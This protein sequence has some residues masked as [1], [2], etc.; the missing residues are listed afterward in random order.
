ML[1]HYFD[2]C[3]VILIFFGKQVIFLAN[4]LLLA[5]KVALMFSLAS[6]NT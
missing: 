2:G 3:I 4:R 5:Y 6:E 1:E